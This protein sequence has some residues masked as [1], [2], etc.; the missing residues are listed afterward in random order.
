MTKVNELHQKWMK[1]REY[2]YAHEDLA[3]EFTL[4]RAVINPGAMEGLTQE[5]LAKRR[6]LA[7]ARHRPP[8]K[9]TD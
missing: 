1:N 4:A 5:Q 7:P 9:R 8:R 6:D 3:P 2:R